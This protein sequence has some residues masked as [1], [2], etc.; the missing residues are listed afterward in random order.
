[1]IRTK[2]FLYC[3]YYFK[4]LYT[5]EDNV[6]EVRTHSGECVFEMRANTMDARVY[7]YIHGRKEPLFTDDCAYLKSTNLEA[8][9][10]KCKVAAAPRGWDSKNILK[11]MYRFD[12]REVLPS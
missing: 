3:D 10:F 2:L 12:E 5:P 7:Q 6:Y 11:F 1:M 8:L 9:F 4:L